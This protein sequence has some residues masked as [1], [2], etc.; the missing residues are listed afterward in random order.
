[1]DGLRRNLGAGLLVVASSLLLFGGNRFR[2][3]DGEAPPAE[4]SGAVR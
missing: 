2:S 1:M 4:G 3:R